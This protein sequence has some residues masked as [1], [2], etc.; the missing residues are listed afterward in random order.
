MREV[1]YCPPT[2]LFEPERQRR[3]WLTRRF[4]SS[5]PIIRTCSPRPQAEN[6]SLSPASDAAATC[7]PASRSSHFSRSPSSVR[8]VESDDSTCH[9]KSSSVGLT[10]SLFA[11]S[12]SEAGSLLAPHGR[13]QKLFFRLVAKNCSGRHYIYERFSWRRWRPELSGRLLL[14]VAVP[15]LLS[16]AASGTEPSYSSLGSSGP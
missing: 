13:P 14:P 12:G 1:P 9:L 5:S 15:G 6:R 11:S 3:W 8:F 10:N 2:P 16:M 7:R 4:A